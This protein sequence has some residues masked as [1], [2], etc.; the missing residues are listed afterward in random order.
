MGNSSFSKTLTILAFLLLGVLAGILLV[1]AM[2]ED[3]GHYLLGAGML[4]AAAAFVIAARIY[5]SK[6]GSDSGAGKKDEQ[7]GDV[8]FVVDT[9]HELVAKLKEKEAELEKLKG[10]A[11]EKAASIETYNENILQSIPSGVITI[12][13]SLKIKSMNQAAERI[14]GVSAVDASGRDFRDVF[15]EP[16]RSLITDE[17]PVFR[18]ESSYT[19]NDNRH[20]WLG[21]TTSGLMKTNGEKI[22]I[23]FVFTDLTDVKALQARVELKERLSRLGEM[24]AGI[25]H[26]LRNSM[27]VISGYAKLLGKRVDEADR[28]TVESIT[29]EIQS[30][31]KI[32]SE[33]LAFAKPTVLNTERV[34]LNDIVREAVEAVIGDSDTVK[35]LIHTDGTEP[36][37]I[38]ADDVLLR[39]AVTNI[40]LNS[41]DA[42]QDGGNIDIELTRQSDRAKLNIRDNGTG[43][44]EETVRKVFLP[45]FTTREQGVGLGLALVQKIIIG[46]EGTVEVLSREG[47]GTAFLITL[48]LAGQGPGAFLH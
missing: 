27:S 18:K 37:L 31:D 13:N 17:Q 26:E 40:L 44:D 39:Q 19:T 30:M 24:S 43:M 4:L 33:L 25:S 5:L 23:I 45:F 7:G 15:D 2:D 9:F 48:P 3:G 41:V 29:S 20:I 38:D 12:D 42:L 6:Q 11:E 46:H 34:D 28:P 32:I 14:L 16:L 21:I 47:E 8:G 1:V 36:L 22:G 35:V 10:L